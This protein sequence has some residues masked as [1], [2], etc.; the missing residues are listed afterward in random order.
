MYTELANE[1]FD[2]TGTFGSVQLTLQYSDDN[3]TVIVHSCKVC[4]PLWSLIIRAYLECQ[5]K[6]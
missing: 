6:K 5:D 2:F 3:L 1:Y 4:I